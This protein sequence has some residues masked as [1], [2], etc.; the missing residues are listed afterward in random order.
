MLSLQTRAYTKQGADACDCKYW[1]LT[2]RQSRNT[3]LV[4]ITLPGKLSLVASNNTNRDKFAA[5][6]NAYLKAVFYINGRLQLRG[7][8]ANFPKVQKNISANECNL[9]FISHQKLGNTQP[10]QK[11][12]TPAR[13]HPLKI[14]TQH[15]NVTW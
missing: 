13:A 9:H 8:V 7:H 15:G 2:F 14:T 3:C 1:K 12:L 6:H 11:S 4:Q 5:K 10:S